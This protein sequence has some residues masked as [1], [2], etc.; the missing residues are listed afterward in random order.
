M[1]RGKG[2][3]VPY[4]MISVVYRWDGKGAHPLN[5]TV[6]DKFRVQV[7][8]LDQ[9]FEPTNDFRVMGAVH[10]V[11]QWLIAVSGDDPISAMWHLRNARTV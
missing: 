6:M 11:A 4:V 5:K 10:A 2:R 1:A 7:M 8:P 9:D 3:V